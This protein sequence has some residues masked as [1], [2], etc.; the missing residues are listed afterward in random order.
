M[1]GKNIHYSQIF[2]GITLTSYQLLSSGSDTLYHRIGSDS[3]YLSSNLMVA[4]FCNFFKFQVF[5]LQVKMKQE[6]FVQI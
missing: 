1:K 6:K 3:S 2:C 4:K 5:H